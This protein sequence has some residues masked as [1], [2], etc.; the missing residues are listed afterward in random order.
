MMRGFALTRFRFS[1]LLWAIAGAWLL[2]GV[3]STWADEAQGDAPD[4]D[5]KRFASSIKKFV[6]DDAEH[7][8]RRVE[9]VFV[10]SS[11]IR[12]WDLEKWFPQ[13]GYLNRGFGGSQ[14][15]DCN[16]YI[17]E[18]ALKHKPQNIVFF[19]GGNDLG[20]KTRSKKS[21][22]QI[23]DDFQQFSKS[24]WAQVP[25]CKVF[26]IAIKPSGRRWPYDADVRDLN[27]KLAEYCASDKRLTFID[28]YPKM[29]NADGKPNSR[30]YRKD[31]LHLSEDGYQIWSNMVRD[32][33]PPQ[34]S[35]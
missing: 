8:D 29:L 12:L 31:E 2:L 17:K 24:L 7:P 13:Q 15:S 34:T 35:D 11:S 25:N 4:P 27:K 22:R 9:T 20:G 28:I 5:P 26:V 16:H 33:L 10:G 19:C 3:C 1:G 18:L 6:A 30:L 14:I 32:V 21:T 23:A